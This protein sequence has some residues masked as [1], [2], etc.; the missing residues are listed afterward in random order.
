MAARTSP[1]AARDA[2]HATAHSLTA[3]P[4]RVSCPATARG[5]CPPS[6]QRPLRASPPRTVRFALVRGFHRASVYGL[7]ARDPP[8]R[9]GLP[10]CWVLGDSI[11]RNAPG[12]GDFSDPCAIGATTARTPTASR[13]SVL[14]A[15]PRLRFETP[16]AHAAPYG[17]PLRSGIP[18]PTAFDSSC[19][20]HSSASRNDGGRG[21]WRETPL[22]PR[23]PLPPGSPFPGSRHATCSA[24]VA[25]APLRSLPPMSKRFRTCR[26]FIS[27]ATTRPVAA[28][29]PHLKGACAGTSRRTTWA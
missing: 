18:V 4:G 1:P 28:R 11:L 21:R 25:P 12:C 7:R 10:A 20:L 9:F 13:A 26:T 16:A 8:L 5:A 29:A 14:S 2:G 24:P 27:A 3:S 6:R 22:Q 23:F 17:L 15:S 19:S